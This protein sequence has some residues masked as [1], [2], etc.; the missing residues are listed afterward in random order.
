MQDT[1]TVYT[2]RSVHRFTDYRDRD[3]AKMLTDDGA[4]A[5]R[6]DFMIY[7]FWQRADNPDVRVDAKY[8]HSNVFV[9]DGFLYLQQ[10]AYTSGE[11]VSMAGIQTRRTD[12][13]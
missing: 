3:I 12:S 7:D 13:E 9:E 4:K 6:E 5:F 2:H 8:D 1:G 11:H 10:K